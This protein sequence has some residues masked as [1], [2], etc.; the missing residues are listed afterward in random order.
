MHVRLVVVFL[1]FMLPACNGNFALSATSGAD[2]ARSWISP[3][4]ASANRLLYISDLGKW[5]VYIYSFPSL[6]IVGKLTGFDN[7]QGECSDSAG[8]VWI[9]NA[10]TEQ[11][12]E[13]AHGSITIRNT[14]S[15][16]VGYPVG[17]AIDHTTGNLAVMNVDDFSGAGSV[18]VYAKARGTPRIYANASAHSY[19]FGGYRNGDLY[20]SGV[21]GKSA[22]VLSRL[23]KGAGSM[24]SIAIAGGTLYFPGTVAWRS[25]TLV[26]GDQRCKNAATSC[27]YDLTLSGKTATI[28]RAIAL[29]N[30]CDVAQAWVGATQVAAGNNAEYCDGGKSRVEIWPYPAGGKPT[31]SISSPRAPVGATVSSIDAR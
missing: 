25:S 9:A 6:I 13:Y 10:G 17:C 18:L 3:L 7:P 27:L 22:Y 26:L 11:M 15:D 24:S 30:S 23:A 19:Y 16:P 8:N 14:L 20:V 2:S 31:A 29:G 12:L 21:S 1:A 5:D 28:K 4:G